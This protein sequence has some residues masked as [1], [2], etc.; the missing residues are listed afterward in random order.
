[1]TLKTPATIDDLFRVEGKAELV[2]GEIILMPATG[3]LPAFAA[4][5]IFASLRECARRTKRGQ[6]RRRQ[7][8]F[9]TTAEG[10]F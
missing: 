5:E 3:A 2:N 1:M 4:D 6:G 8:G 10:S 9:A 7:Q